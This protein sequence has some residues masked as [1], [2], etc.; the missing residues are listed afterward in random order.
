MIS[1]A[2]LHPAVLLSVA[3]SFYRLRPGQS[4]VADVLLF[5]N[6]P[7][8]ELLAMPTRDDDDRGVL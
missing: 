3:G 5:D 6:L 4:V 2:L 1:P 8:E 7:I